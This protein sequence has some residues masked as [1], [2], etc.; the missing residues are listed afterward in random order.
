MTLKYTRQGYAKTVE[1]YTLNEEEAKL[2]QEA[3]KEKIWG[4]FGGTVEK[5]GNTLIITNYVD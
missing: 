3:F 2:P 4:P 5:Y 1:V